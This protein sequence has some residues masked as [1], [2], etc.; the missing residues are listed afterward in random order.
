[1][2]T[3]LFGER[4][5]FTARRLGGG[6]FEKERERE[7]KKRPF[8]AAAPQKAAVAHDFTSDDLMAAE[9]RRSRTHGAAPL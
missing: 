8:C 5:D 1:M 9:R 4:G 6:G 2:F 7:K 3:P